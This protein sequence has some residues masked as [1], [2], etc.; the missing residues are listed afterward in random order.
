[1]TGAPMLKATGLWEKTSA[2]GNTYLTGRL[3]GVKVL[4]LENRDRNGDSEPSHH[5]FF[6]DGSKPAETRNAAPARS[7][8]SSRRTPAALQRGGTFP[9]DSVSALWPEGEP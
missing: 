1:M 6:V 9:N 2:A 7:A 4:I 8:Y 5:L 3:G